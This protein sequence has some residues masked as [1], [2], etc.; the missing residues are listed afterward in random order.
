MLS[1]Y[2]RRYFPGTDSAAESPWMAA[3]T[4][5]CE[6]KNFRTGQGVIFLAAGPGQTFPI[7]E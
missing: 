3:N 5:V 4:H 7:L 2:I 1:L 6:L